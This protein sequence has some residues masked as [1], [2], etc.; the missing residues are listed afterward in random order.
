[1][2]NGHPGIRT[3]YN[4]NQRD[5]DLHGGKIMIDVVEEVYGNGGVS[6]ALHFFTFESGALRGKQCNF[7]EHEEPVQHNEDYYY[8]NFHEKNAAGPL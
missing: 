3:F 1:M 4:T 5:A 6:A 2:A 7:S 8:G